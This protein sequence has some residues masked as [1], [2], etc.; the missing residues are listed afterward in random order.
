MSLE[1]SLLQQASLNY[2]RQLSWLLPHCTHITVTRFMHKWPHVSS[3]LSTSQWLAIH[4]RWK[5]KLLNL[6]LYDLMPATCLPCQHYPGHPPTISHVK[7]LWASWESMCSYSSTS[8]LLGPL[9]EMPFYL[10]TQ[11]CHRTAPRTL[12]A[13]WRQ[14]EFTQVPHTALH[15]PLG[16]P[17]A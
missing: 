3:P 5:F 2:L 12:F 4:I 9:P 11:H 14:E 13:E 6:V 17:L 15:T 8:K 1:S 10:C 16:P 7:L